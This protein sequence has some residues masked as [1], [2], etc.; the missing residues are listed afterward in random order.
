MKRSQNRILTTPTGSLPRPADL[1]AMMGGNADRQTLAER[2]RSAV[3]ETVRRQA[4]AGI[5]IV[6][7]GEMSKPSFVHYVT[8]RIRGFE[9]INTD[10]LGLD[11]DEGFSGYMAWRRPLMTGGNPFESRPECIAPLV[12]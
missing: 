2:V 12:W 10:P 4:D 6:S 5:D 9:G 1:L 7:D 11:L 8:G 3:A